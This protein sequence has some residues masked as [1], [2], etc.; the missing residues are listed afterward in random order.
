[1][2]ENFR[3][4]L[5]DDERPALENLQIAVEKAVPDSK[6]FMAQNVSQ[7]L[8]IM[9]DEKPN[10]AMLD[11]E[12]P[13]MNGLRLAKTLKDM[14]GEINIIFVTAYD[15]YAVQAFG[16]KA[17]GYLLKPVRPDSIRNELDDLRKP[18]N[19]EKT[20]L[21]LKCFGKFEVYYD[22]E[23]VV[24][25]RSAEKEILAY[26]TD[27]CGDGAGTDEICGILWEDS[28][29]RDRRKDYFRV[30]TNELKHTLGQYGC[31]NALIS[32]RNYYALNVSEVDCDYYRYLKGDVSAVNSYHGEY[33]SQY[34]WAEMT[35]G[36]LEKKD[37]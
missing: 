5:V 11:I 7:A 37:E 26:L 22:N 33:M 9:S 36:K 32:K 31:G 28:E 2:N 15:Q 17:S 24:F 19:G 23:P 6:I 21:Y 13:E 8:D 3:I 10:V 18:V 1:M 35:V 16:I 29:E 25:S 30:L 34:S 12:M 20:R 4:L 14:N 27:L